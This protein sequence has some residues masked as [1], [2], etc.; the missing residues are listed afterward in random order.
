TVAVIGSSPAWKRNSRS[1]WDVANWVT[2]FSMAARRSV[3][4]VFSVKR[5]ELRRV[6]VCRSSTSRLILRAL[7]SGGAGTLG[8]RGEVHDRA[9]GAAHLV[10]DHGDEILMLLVRLFEFVIG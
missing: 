6:A 2:R 10:G 7:F 8:K 1:R 4:W 3:G 5:P 9:K